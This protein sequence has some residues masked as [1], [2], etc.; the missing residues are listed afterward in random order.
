MVTFSERTTRLRHV[1]KKQQ[2][3]S[4][5]ACRDQHR[6]PPPTLLQDIGDT[7]QRC[8]A[9]PCWTLLLFQLLLL[10]QLLGWFLRLLNPPS[11]V[12]L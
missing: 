3:G 10:L 1:K 9:P 4:A 5:G 8:L 11:P 2:Q 7:S 6:P 12:S